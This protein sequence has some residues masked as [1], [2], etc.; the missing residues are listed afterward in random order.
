MNVHPATSLVP[1]GEV[2]DFI[3]GVTFKPDD[4]VP[5]RTPALVA[6]FRT[7]NVQEDLDLSDVWALS[8][9]FAAKPEKLVR[10]GDIIVSSAN[11]WNLV[12]KC[13]WVPVLPW[14]ATAG[15]FVGVL[16]ATSKNLE[17]RYLYWWFA[18]IRTQEEV[19]N[20]ARQT[21]NI[22]NLNVSLLR[23]LEIKHEPDLFFR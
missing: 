23:Q 2:T 22:A 4:V 10:L 18:S 6:C 20:C 9:R 1:L 8:E 19:R 13:S 11:S 15:G 17:P 7:K 16:R 12:G 14:K 21:T 3:R 5:L